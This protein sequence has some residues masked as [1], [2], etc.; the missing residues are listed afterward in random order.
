VNQYVVKPNTFEMDLWNKYD[1]VVLSV[2]SAA[3]TCRVIDL[4]TTWNAIDYDTV[5]H[6][7][8]AI[9]NLLVWCRLL[10]YYSSFKSIGVLIIMIMEMLEDM[11]LWITLSAVFMLA[12]TVTFVS[13]AAEADNVNDVLQVPAWAMY[14]EFDPDQMFEWSPRYGSAM[15]WVYVLVSNVLLVNLLIAM[16]SDSYAE[17]KDNAD[18][19]WKFGRMNS[20]LETVERIHPIPP[21]LSLPMLVAKFSTTACRA[22]FCAIWKNA[23]QC[24]G[25][26]KDESGAHD[27]DDSPE[28]QVGG[29]S[30]IQKRLREDITTAA[31]QEH[32]K[33]SEKQEQESESARSAR[34]ESMLEDV[35]V[36]CESH[37]RELNSL[38]DSVHEVA[39]RQLSADQR[40]QSACHSSARRSTP[41]SRSPSNGRQV[42]GADPSI[43]AP[44]V[45]PPPPSSAGGGRP[46]SSKGGSSRLRR[47]I[48]FAGRDLAA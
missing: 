16:M 44:A 48:G 14:G 24:G 11:A 3:L 37:D 21:P 20:V 41:Q 6:S 39:Q 27:D 2:T 5:Q 47:D 1:Y 23:G 32:R 17:I 40:S 29:R 4:S 7:L 18:V 8:L 26:V 31:L 22:F 9:N 46:H 30:W 13:I 10:Q 34:I 15:L 12:F 35:L 25:C 28:W 19:E 45:L 33:I 38:R 42:G 43:P 36:M